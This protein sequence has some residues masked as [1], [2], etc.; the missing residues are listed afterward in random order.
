MK[1]HL[2]F[3]FS[4]SIFALSC[5][6]TEK[7]EAV[8]APEDPAA[9]LKAAYELCSRYDDVAAAGPL[10]Y[11]LVTA[12]PTE[13]AKWKEE[14]AKIH[15]ATQRHASCLKILEDLTSQH[16]LS[17]KLPLLEMKALCHEALGQRQEATAAWKIVWE[18]SGSALHAVRLA[19][20]QFED[21]ALEDA[22]ASITAGLAASDSKTA[23][24]PLPKTR[25]E[26]QQIPA[27]A[28]LHNLKALLLIKQAPGAKDAVRAELEAAL[29]LAPDFEIAKR[30]LSGL[31]ASPPAEGESAPNSSSSPPPT[32]TK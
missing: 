13:A 23:T 28:A 6:D 27:A 7:L 3:I 5:N 25:E 2:I 14:L 32:P 31:E 20:R 17:E 16:G 9:H 12:V 8:H 10:A 1:Y 26:M 18:K 30:N 11:Q 15:F 19:G 22:Q 24:L 4:V 21:D 29:A